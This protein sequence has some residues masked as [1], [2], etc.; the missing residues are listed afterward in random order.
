MRFHYKKTKVG[1][2]PV[3]WDLVAFGDIITYTKGFPFKSA[4]YQ[5][6][7]VRIVRVGDTTFNSIE[8]DDPVYIAYDKAARYARWALKEHDLIIST[9][10]SKPPMYSSMVGRVVLV[11]NEHEGAL[12]N[13]NAVLIRYKSRKPHVQ[14]LLLHHFRTKR[15]LTFIEEIFRGNA[16]QA[17][18][19]LHELFLFPLALPSEESEQEAI[20]SALGDV[21]ALLRALDQLIVKKRDLKVAVAQ[22]L[23]TGRQRLP[24]FHGEWLIKSIGN[25][26]DL[27]TGFPFSSKDYSAKGIRLLRGSNVKRGQIDW[28]NGIAQYWPAVTHEISP[29]VLQDGDLVIAMDGALVGR[30]FARLSRDD[31]PAL[32]VQRVARIRSAKIDVGYLAQLIGTDL[33]SKYCDSVKTVT[34]IPHISSEDIRRFKIPIPPTIRE[35]AAIANILS[36][37]ENEI[38]A[39]EI[40][41]DKTEE[42]KQGMMQELLT[43]KTRLV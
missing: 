30:S 25:D 10:G 1:L 5:R 11:D 21:D 28:S 36:D 33:F 40:R 4:D 39:L 16:N 17:S 14:Q 43:G 20:A 34:A 31:L 35:Q 18:I 13:Q 12:L 38:S 22:Q 24:G 32:L 27:L 42:L 26:I 15:Y 41:R 7:G 3:D 29:Y 2:I 9:V 37:I 8:D 19:T 6:D 23:L